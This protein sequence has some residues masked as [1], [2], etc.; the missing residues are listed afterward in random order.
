M[1][2]G[3]PDKQAKIKPRL[4]LQSVLHW[5]TYDRAAEDDGLPTYDATMIVTTTYKGRQVPVPG[6][7][8]AIEDYG[9]TEHSARRVSQALQ[10]KLRAVLDQQGYSLK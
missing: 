10:A 2:L 3:W 8:E 7:P 4:P 9:W 1:T 5:K 6:K